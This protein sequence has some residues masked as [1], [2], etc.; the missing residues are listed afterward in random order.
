ME[1][2]RSWRMLL[3]GLAR[4]IFALGIIAGSG[5]TLDWLLRLSSVPPSPWNLSGVVPLLAGI[6]LESLGTYAIWKLGWGTPH[7][8]SHPVILVR[9]GPYSK[10]RNPL[11]LGRLL[12]LTGLGF[13]AGSIGILALT[14]VLFG[15]LELV[16]VPREEQ[17]LQVRFGTA[18]SEYR[19]SVGRWLTF[20]S[21]GPLKRRRE[22]S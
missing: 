11:Y 7:P 3:I 14:V 6:C 22:G 21:T 12:V 20:G 5:V 15:C 16:L 17:R 1:S 13:L 10:S 8:R 19:D 18:Y 9:G 4:L 2:A